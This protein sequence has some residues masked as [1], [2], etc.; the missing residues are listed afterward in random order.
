MGLLRPAYIRP[1]TLYRYYTL[2]QLEDAH[3]IGKLR[4]LGMPLT[5]VREALRAWGTPELA[6]HLERHREA[7]L[8]QAT[9]VHVALEHVE[10]LLN[11]PGQPYTVQ[12]KPVAAQ[13]YLGTRAWCDPDEAC[14]YFDHAQQHLLELS[15]QTLLDAAGP[16]FARYH[17]DERDDV[18]DV[19]VGLPVAGRI[20]DGL[21]PEVFQGEL[22]SGVVAYTVHAGACEGSRGMQAAYQAVWSWL[23]DHGHETHGGP[24]EIYLFDGLNTDAP[25]DYRTE[26][27]WHLR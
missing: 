1:N 19:E 5:N 26:V 15:K 18:W 20:P 24:L 2:S 16:F 14:A 25:D 27:A 22:P 4:D 17:D 9:T 11:T 7:L 23:R 12:T 21:P 6:A 3:R 13:R 10:Q 8:R